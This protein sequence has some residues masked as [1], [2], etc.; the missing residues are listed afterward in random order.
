MFIC[1][2]IAYPIGLVKIILT[3]IINFIEGITLILYHTLISN[4]V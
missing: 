1:Y 2:P 4:I 3:Q